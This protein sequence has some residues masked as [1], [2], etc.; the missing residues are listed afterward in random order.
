MENH[1]F[2]RKNDVV[3]LFTKHM[4]KLEVP[5]V[6]NTCKCIHVDVNCINTALKIHNF[7][8]TGMCIFKLN[9]DLIHIHWKNDLFREI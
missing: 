9:V 4:I 6:E 3:C 7:V 5:E 2:E 8:I 1:S